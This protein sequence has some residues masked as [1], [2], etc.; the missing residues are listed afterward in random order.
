MYWHGKELYF[1]PS[2]IDIFEN[3]YAI[4]IEGL[5]LKPFTCGGDNEL[6][7]S[8]GFYFKVVWTAKVKLNYGTWIFSIFVLMKSESN[9]ALKRYSWV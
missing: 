2:V 8:V 7:T 9:L 1:K 4:L 3:K 5:F 6:N